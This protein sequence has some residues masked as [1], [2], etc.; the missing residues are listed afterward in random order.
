MPDK[1]FPSGLWTGYYQ[2][3]NGVRGQQ[4]LRLSFAHGRMSGTGADEVG[5]FIVEGSYSNDTKEAQW[6][7]SYPCGHAIEYRG[8]REGPVEGIWGTWKISANWHGGFHI[9]TL[10][11]ENAVVEEELT[12]QDEIYADP[13]IR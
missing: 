2:Y 4:D 10:E 5:Q 12:E 8:F 3:Q 11:N 9:W 1:D 7:K 13:L 6:L